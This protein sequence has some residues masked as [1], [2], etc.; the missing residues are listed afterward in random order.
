MKIP[1]SEML[2][3]NDNLSIQSCSK[4][5]ENMLVLTQTADDIT[6]IFALK[7]NFGLNNGFNREQIAAIDGKILGLTV[8]DEIH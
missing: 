7:V 8:A 5:T 6:E 2:S 1:P 3:N 4:F